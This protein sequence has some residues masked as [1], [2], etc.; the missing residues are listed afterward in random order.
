MALKHSSLVCKKS[1]RQEWSRSCGTTNWRYHLLEPFGNSLILKL[2]MTIDGPYLYRFSNETRQR[3][4][5]SLSEPDD[6]S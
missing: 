3:L 1:R 4:S 2:E 6:A 5:E